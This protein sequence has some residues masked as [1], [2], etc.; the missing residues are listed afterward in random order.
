MKIAVTA[1]TKVLECPSFL[2]EL[3]RQRLTF[4]NP[5]YVEA[6]KMGRSTR[7]LQPYLKYFIEIGNTIITPRGVTRWVIEH[8]KKHGIRY[9]LIDNRRSLEPVEFTFNGRL[10]DYQRKAVEDVIRR[11]FGVLTAPTG[12]GKTVMALAVIA[13]RKQP[14]LIIV[15][16]KE[17]ADQWVSRISNFLG[18]P[19]KEV[20]RIGSGKKIVA[21]ITVATIQTLYKC[22]DEIAPSFGQIIVDE[23]HRTPARTFS[24]A[25]FGFD[26]RYMLGLS[27]TPWRR[28]GLSDLIY[29]FMGEK[30]HEIPREQLLKSRTIL[31]LELITRKTNFKAYSDPTENYAAAMTELVGDTERNALIINDVIRLSNEVS[32]AVLVLSDRKDHLVLLSK[33]IK[34]HGYNCDILTGDLP[35][36]EGAEI[37][38]RLNRNEIRILLATSQLIGEGFDCPHLC[39]LVLATPVRFSGRVLQYLGR[40]LRPAPGKD[41]AIVVDYCD[42]EEGVFRHS[43]E[44]RLKIF[45]S[46]V[47]SGGWD[48]ADQDGSEAGL[49]FAW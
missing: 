10:R 48:V 25:V 15:H 4:E 26:C 44:K 35:R 39:A 33:L 37:V 49:A 23:C 30:V 27:A 46:L 14:T 45:R 8:A 16:T 13:I 18:I 34:K 12:S 40:V 31:P 19:A 28:D 5:S 38:E 41:K 17:L 47:R 6:E 2:R 7:H 20:G 24:D 21:P 36:S 29:C 1:Q 9:E 43:F 22:V 32:G 3:L 42:W 11:D